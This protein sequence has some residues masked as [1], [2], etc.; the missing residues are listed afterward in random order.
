[1][2]ERRCCS[3]PAAEV[4]CLVRHFDPG[5]TW[6]SGLTIAQ[7][8]SKVMRRFAPGAWVGLRRCMRAAGYARVAGEGTSVMGYLV[9]FSIRTTTEKKNSD[10]RGKPHHRSPFRIH[11]VPRPPCLPLRHPYA[12]RSSLT[13]RQDQSSTAAHERRA[14]T[15]VRLATRVSHPAARA[16]GIDGDAEVPRAVAWGEL[17]AKMGRRRARRDVRGVSGQRRR[18]M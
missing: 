15:T 13:R 17:A 12:P 18:N 10:M 2:F 6:G 16:A 11:D 14:M 8:E 7:R 4:I 3:S 1:M 9:R 5:R